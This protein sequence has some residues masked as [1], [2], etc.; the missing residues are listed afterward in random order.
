MSKFLSL[1]TILGAA[2]I[3]HSQTTV[4]ITGKVLGMTGTPIVGAIV[5]FKSL[6]NTATT[7]SEGAYSFNGP[8]A[9]RK[10]EGYR[11]AMVSQG[12]R[13]SL[14]LDQR[15]PVSIQIFGLSGRLVRQVVD[16]TLDGGNHAFD[17]AGLN[18]ANQLYLVK[19]RMGAQLGW[20]KLT[21]QG[22]LSYITSVG[23]VAMDRALGKAAASVAADS[24]Y[25]THAEYHGGLA[26]IN[27]RSVTAMTGTQNFRMFSTDKGWDACAPTFNFKFDQS[28]GALYYQK[29]IA[30]PE[31]TNQEALREVCQSIWKVPADIPSNRKFTSY[32]ANINSSVSTGVASTGGNSLNFNVGYIDQQKGRGD[33][34]AWYEVVGVLIHEGTHS[35]QPYYST[36]GASGF[37]EAV[38]DAIRALTGFFKWPTGNKCSGSFTEAYQTGGKYW[39]FIEQKHPGFINAVYKLTSGDISARVQ[40]VTGE[41]LNAMVT[42]CQTKGMP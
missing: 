40:Q 27:G 20:H 33:A 39:Y 22:G 5:K 36:T 24:L 2:T 25:V 13:L 16:R 28:A 6:S 10:A 35:Y 30:G 3:L 7:N 26:K 42:E 9:L 31:A 12:S 14:S 18:Q 19:V 4:N 8:L 11:L 23:E 34:A 15:E 37:G 1:T 41:S 32:T 21:Y 17:L 38:P 29:I